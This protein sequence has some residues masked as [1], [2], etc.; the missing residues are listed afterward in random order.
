VLGAVLMGAERPPPE[1]VYPHFGHPVGSIWEGVHVISPTRLV[2]SLALALGLT[3][4]AASPAQAGGETLK[5]SVS[6][7]LFAPVDLA[8]APAVA[9][10]TMYNNLKNVGDSTAVRYFY[11]PFG[12][13]WL[14]GVQAGASVLRAVT[15]CIEFLPGLALLPFD[16]EMPPIFDPAERGGAYV[17]KDTPPLHIKFGI[18]YTTPPS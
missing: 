6:N 9:G 11:P 7:I 16:A 4:G 1:G 13:L 8:L 14:T 18:D 10:T 2:A 12:Y 15:G 3:A 17:D 5:R